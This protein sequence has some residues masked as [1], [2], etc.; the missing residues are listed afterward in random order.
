M[1]KHIVRKSLGLIVL[2]AVIIVGIFVIQFR[3]DSIIRKTIRSMRVTLVEAE[4]TD[5]S[6]ALKNQFQIA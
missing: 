2:Y 1:R 4:S 6:A 3:S 5:G